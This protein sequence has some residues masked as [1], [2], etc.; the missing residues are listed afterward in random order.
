MLPEIREYERTSTTVINAYLQPVVSAYLDR[1]RGMLRRARQRGPLLVMQSAGGL[2]SADLASR[3]PAGIVESG[4][5]P[6]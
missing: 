1:L 6:G 3:F 2:M 4:P 5:A